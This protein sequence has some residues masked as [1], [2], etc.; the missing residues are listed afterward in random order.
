MRREDYPDIGPVMEMGPE[1]YLAALYERLGWEPGTE[2]DPMKITIN[3][4]QW[5]EI[6]QSFNE[7]PTNGIPGYLWMNMGPSADPDVPYGVVQIE[8]GAFKERDFQ[9][10]VQEDQTAIDTVVHELFSVGKDQVIHL[11]KEDMGF[12]RSLLEEAYELRRESPELFQEKMHDRIAR[13]WL[14]PIDTTVE[15]ILQECGVHP[16]EEE[17]YEAARDYLLGTY[18]LR[19]P[20]EELMAE[21]V[22]V[23]LLLGTDA[24]RNFD[25][26]CVAGMKGLNEEDYLA[27]EE[28]DN[29]LTWL[30]G[31]QGHD[32]EEFKAVLRDLEC[33]DTGS[34]RCL[35]GDFLASA[36]QELM[37]F[38]HVMGTV[39]VLTEIPVA[40]LPDLNAPGN[41]IVLDKG[42][43]V[44]LFAP[45]VGGGSLFG[46]ELEKELA[47]PTNLV[48]E[49]QVEGIQC[50]EYT[51]NRVYGLVDE[52][53]K[54]PK[55]IERGSGHGERPLNELVKEAKARAGT[56][57]A[58]AHAAPKDRKSP[59]MGR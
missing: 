27:D 22:Q 52:A 12:D 30:I 54:E 39:T 34:C 23:N 8:E 41:T 59:E 58:E 3:E 16:H 7:Y 48:F 42:A 13:N 18:E 11:D 40:S 36:A 51:V 19:P 17:R 33:L 28:K 49:T 55:A 4:T 21:K 37:D 46:V 25:F 24:E 56:R 26:S 31:Q 15:F 6:C 9:S 38:N 44:G 53:W 20:Y 57:A 1:G 35:H 10:V 2:L 5:L 32:L 43:E 45:W 50:D 14:E 29:A 47:I